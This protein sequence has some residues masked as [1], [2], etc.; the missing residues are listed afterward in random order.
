MR[1]LNVVT[2][3]DKKSHN[4]MNVTVEFSNVTAIESKWTIEGMNLVVKNSFLPKTHF[5]LSNYKFGSSKLAVVIMSTFGQLTVDTGF[6]IQISDCMLKGGP[7]ERSALID[8]RDSTI[9]ITTSNFQ[10][11]KTYTGPAV[12]NAKSCKV[13][14]E[15]SQF[16]ANIGKHGVIQVGKQTNITIYNS[17]FF[18]NGH[19]FLAEATVLVKSRSNAV[20]KNCKFFT[21]IASTGSCIRSNPGTHLDVQNSTFFGNEG[22]FGGVIYCEG[23]LYSK[24]ETDTHET[25]FQ[26]QFNLW[27]ATK[28]P[29]C[30]IKKSNFTGNLALQRGGNAYFNQTTAIVTD[31]HF[32]QSSSLVSGGVMMVY[33]SNIFID[34]TNFNVSGT[35]LEGGVF[36]AADDCNII[37]NNSIVSVST[38]MR[39]S[40]FQIQSRVVLLMNNVTVNNGNAGIY[41]F[42]DG[43]SLSI[44]DRCSV[45]VMNSYFEAV[46]PF[47]WI[48]F[49]EDNSNLTVL[50]STFNT[51]GNSSTQIVS[52]AKSSRVNFTKCLFQKIAG[53]VVSDNSSLLMKD[54]IMRES[55]YVISGALISAS[56]NSR[57]KI[58]ET[59]ITD[60]IPNVDLPFVRLESSNVS[61]RKCLY[62]GNRLS[63]HIVA[64]GN[65]LIS[66]SDSH[67][68]NNTFRFGI[69]YSSIFYLT[70]SK[71]SV[72]G[73]VFKNN[74]QY[75]NFGMYNVAI[76][77]AYSSNVEINNCTFITASSLIA[78]TFIFHMRLASITEDSRNYLQISHSMFNN[79]GGS[80]RVENIADVNIQSSFFQIHPNTDFP[81]EGSGL[82]LSGLENLRIADSHFNS[83]EDSKTQVAI[84]YTANG[85]HFLTS[86]SNFTFGNYS[87]KSNDNNFV[88]KAQDSGLITI[89]P[90]VRDKHTETSYASSRYFKKLQF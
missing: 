38:A 89:P 9:N 30:L 6:H 40:S 72:D 74:Y 86:Y 17:I 32:Q 43:Y 39:G 23:A 13:Y 33:N 76:V 78:P 88:E 58:E 73:T 52:A 18:N 59:N 4:S 46:Y 87:L 61:V 47:P 66:V 50:E 90:E 55:Q 54:S 37:V 19:W 83:S 14:L 51:K 21:N 49:M 5:H 35:V 34:N 77:D 26:F 80:L 3:I 67:F 64:T 81:L 8:I 12:L 29:Q 69:M 24:R 85:F 68:N 28:V 16:E 60:I 10:G 65:S 41:V 45:N 44:S 20:L 15:N 31:C 1:W 56:V 22:A 7:F 27:K 57:I 42:H 79:K 62:S 48:F 82:Q 2:Y 11:F 53:L 25:K 75:K 63:R 71:L 70:R 84:K 36:D